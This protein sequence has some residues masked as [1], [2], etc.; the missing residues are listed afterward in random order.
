MLNI[1]YHF[2]PLYKTSR[3]IYG[4][5]QLCLNIA[6]AYILL[7][8]E[9]NPLFINLLLSCDVLFEFVLESKQTLGEGPCGYW[10]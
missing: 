8:I 6:K 1:L 5:L 10:T 9:K 4:F 2:R 7:K 3:Y